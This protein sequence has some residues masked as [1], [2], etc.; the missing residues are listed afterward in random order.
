M[1][2]HK[3]GSSFA[4]PPPAWG[5]SPSKRITHAA[6]IGE[7]RVGLGVQE[8]EYTRGGWQKNYFFGGNTLQ[9]AIFQSFIVLPPYPLP[10]TYDGW[11]RAWG[12]RR[13]RFGWKKFSIVFAPYNMFLA[14]TISKLR[15]SVLHNPST[16]STSKNIWQVGPRVR[17]KAGPVWV[18]KVF[19]CLRSI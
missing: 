2:R 15:F 5:L 6:G 13:A 11:V 9:I 18:R 4:C 1:C 3:P 19:N 8:G 7:V 12:V 16:L 17:G 14:E 10:K